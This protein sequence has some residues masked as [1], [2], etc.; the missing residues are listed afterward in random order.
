MSLVNYVFRRKRMHTC[1]TPDFG[2][3][4]KNMNRVFRLKS[5]SGIVKQNEQLHQ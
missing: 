1:E 5:P 2:G 3:L 4:Y